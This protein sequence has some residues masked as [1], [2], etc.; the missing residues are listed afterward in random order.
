MCRLAQAVEN[1]AELIAIADP[2]GR[3][4]FANRALLHATG[5]QESEIVGQP[6]RIMLISRNNPPGLDQEIRARTIFDG[7]WRGECLCRRKDDSEFPVFLSSGQIK[8]SHG[9]VIGIF[10]MAQ[11]ITE[12][13]SLEK[14]LVV[15]QKMEAVGLL[16]GGI[17]HDFN[18]LLGV[19]I[20]YSEIF[21]DD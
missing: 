1:S 2:D 7:G 12:R 6:F 21:E 10:G 8:D 19:I 15:S 17:A 14:Q 16:A 4:S 18:N 9:L 11:D 20:G 13:K 5:Y 3:I